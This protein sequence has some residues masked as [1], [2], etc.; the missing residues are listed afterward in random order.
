MTR[1]VTLPEHNEVAVLATNNRLLTTVLEVDSVPLEFFKVSIHENNADSSPITLDAYCIYPPSFRENDGLL[2]PVIFHVYGEPANQTVKK[3]WGGK[4]SLWHRMLAQKGAFVISIDNRGTPSLKGRNWRKIVYRQIGI[5]ASSD[6]AAAVESILS[7]R[8]YLDRSRV[9]VWGWSGGGSMTLNALFRYPDL[10]R[11]AVSVAPVP[12]M[13]LYDTIYQERYMDLPQSNPEGYL[14]GSPITYAHQMKEE[15]NL[16]II[17]G[18]GDD[19]CHYQG[20]EL[21]VNQL[22]KHNKPFQM[23]AYPNRSHSISEGVNT[24]RHLFEQITR[25]LVSTKIVVK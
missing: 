4:L 18:T 1:I 20:T 11:T 25:F 21:L 19:N 9:C 17:H 2:Y 22:I 6:Q 23:L 8:K 12:D 7:N 10:Y 13:R 24:V 14:N 15:Q 3:Q 16:L 5:L